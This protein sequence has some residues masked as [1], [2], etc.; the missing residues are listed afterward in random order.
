MTKTEI[1]QT[2][3]Q[4][5]GAGGY[6]TTSLQTLA[7]KL[8]VSKTALYRYFRS[9]DDILVAMRET[10]LDRFAD[11]LRPLFESALSPLEERSDKG[12]I[13]DALLLVNNGITEF[14]AKNPWYFVFS[15][16]KL[17]GNTD[18]RLEIEAYLRARGLDFKKL[19]LAAEDGLGEK[20][21]Y[22]A[23]SQL[24]FTYSLCIIANFLKGLWEEGRLEENFSSEA[25]Q[26]VC[27]IIR[28][29]GEAVKNGLRFSRERVDALDWEALEAAAKWTESGENLGRHKGLIKA[30]AS[31]V[32]AAG[33]WAASMSMVAKESGLS[34]SGLYAHFSSKR[35]MLRQLF[36]EEFDEVVRY[37][38]DASRKSVV[39]E[40]QLYLAIR[41][42]ED[43]LT[44]EP[45]FLAAISSLKTQNIN[46]D[47]R[48]M[49]GIKED[50]KKNSTECRSRFFQVFSEIKNARGEA[51]ID[52]TTTGAILFLLT[53]TLIRKPESMDYKAIPDQSLR[54]LYRFIALGTNGVK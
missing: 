29:V 8:G 2:A 24:V 47:M 22:P 5:W 3:F 42:V 37:A 20:D 26:G 54:S 11:S 48:M 1:I 35:D 9:K 15:L 46:L 6:Q 32:A 40:A 53:D 43:F 18:V 50:M 4:T 21:A 44:S 27:E 7:D 52:E 13:L 36:L 31:A 39:P 45:E 25:P 51:L 49:D 30:V 12:K 28:K 41:A 33:P 10:F 34:K 23:L 14:F 19:R 16:V 17:H 38:R